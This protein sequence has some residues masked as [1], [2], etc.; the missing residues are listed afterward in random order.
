MP[1]TDP[2]PPTSCLARGGIEAILLTLAA[3]SPWAFGAVH[4]L[5]LLV[6]YVGVSACLALWAVALVADRRPPRV[7]C[8]VALCLAGMVLLG[9]WQLTPLPRSLLAVVAPGSERA[10]SSLLPD[11]P[12]VIE[13]SAS[14]PPA[15]TISLYPRATRNQVVQLLAALAVFVLAR[16]VVASTACLKRLAVVAVV[17]G[18]LL[19]VFA[20]LQMFSSPPTR[21][22]WAFESTGAAFG[23]FICR[24]HFPF[25]VNVC[26]GL[27]L[28]LLLSRL[29]YNKRRGEDWRNALLDAAMDPAT[30]WLAASLGLML[31]AN[32]YS[33]SRGGVL[34]LAGAVAIGLLFR[35]AASK[36]ERAGT[37]GLLLVAGFA[38]ALVAWF[39]VNRVEKRL[40][41]IWSGDALG[42]GRGRL[43]ERTLPI[44]FDHPVW[45]AGYGTFDT[46]ETTRR[47][48]GDAS[49]FR[50]EYAHNDYL[51]TLVEGGVVHLALALLAIAL[52]YR[53]A[54]S[55]YRLHPKSAPVILGGMIGL[56]TV[57][58][59]SF[60]DFGLH[61]PSIA[62]LT[63]LLA[64]LLVGVG[65]PAGAAASPGWLALPAA[66][67][68]LVLAALLPLE[69]WKH[70]RAERL[71]LASLR[72]TSRLERGDRDRV[73]RYLEGAVAFQPDDAL[74]LLQLA[75]ARR[76]MYEA[77]EGDPEARDRYLLPAL[78]AY[79]RAR[80]ANPVLVE[81]HLWLGLYRG[82]MTAGDTART[83]LGRAAR[84]SPSDPRVWYLAGTLALREGAAD[85]AWRD[86]RRSLECDPRFL[87]DILK[88]VVARPDAVAILDEVLPDDPRVLQGAVADP[89]LEKVP[90]TRAKLLRRALDAAGSGGTAEARHRRGWLLR[91]LDEPARA[92]EE[93]GHAV[94][95]APNKPEWRLEFAELLIAQRKQADAIRQLRRVLETNP[96]HEK[97]RALLNEAVRGEGKAP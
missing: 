69:G 12:E 25:F 93:Y 62:L 20:F 89:S 35:A 34:A 33:Q 95:L 87:A 31:A 82:E 60:G 42:D 75:E 43:W 26:V 55:A 83:Y 13:G 21:L 76:G 24:N 23:P 27:G 56:T 2:P 51:Q 91:E 67:S 8:P 32:L 84:L 70:E 57:V 81:P 68:C 11:E 77:H 54:V 7:V 48:P 79:R 29:T 64:G 4:Q 71:R 96:R 15:H 63:A 30:V 85:E 22:Y 50:F 14:S 40:Q 90:Q 44:A 61:V 58:I 73:I 47:E 53:Y 92:I 16:Y 18:T 6:L 9:V 59:H 41:T 78:E 46:L 38:V 72:A 3:L 19:S 49:Q 10:W 66:L 5:S 74:L 1:R 28:G 94:D 45:G 37:A 36:P 80:N 17:D 65:S 39:G 88:A 86:W 97:A 52:V